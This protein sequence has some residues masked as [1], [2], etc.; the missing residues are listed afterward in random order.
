ML[1][2]ILVIQTASIGD[3]ILATPLIEKL[4]VFYPDA[5]IDVLVKNGNQGLFSNH[6][7]INSVIVWTKNRRKKR[8]FS[9]TLYDIRKSKYD[10]V[11]NIQR[12]LSTG[13]LTAFS[14]SKIR[15]GFSKNPLSLFF[16]SRIKHAILNG[17]HEVDRNL[18]L[19]EKLTDNTKSK[20]KLYPSAKDH[21]KVNCYK[22]QVYY[23]ISPGSLWFTKKFPV[24]K[25]VELVSKIDKNSSIIFLGSKADNE[26]C[27]KIIRLSGIKNVINLSGHLSFL[28]SAALMMDAKMNFTND[29]GPMHLASSVNAPVTVIFCSTIPGFGFGPLSDQ[30]NIVEIRKK[31]SCRPCGLHGLKSCPKGHF[32]CAL[33][34]NVNQLIELL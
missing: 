2:K 20:P 10:A 34:I 22:N 5:Q 17:I 15:I 21:K 9:W 28:E 29:S 31:L 19:I 18:I 26:M 3:V 32:R 13:I 16:T 4:H 27:D 14:G 12:F 8:N 6:P 23:T 30:S 25:W 1:K 24:D 7:F 11:I 33:D